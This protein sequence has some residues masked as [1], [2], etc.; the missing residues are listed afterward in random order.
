M[1]LLDVG[2]LAL[3]AIVVVLLALLAGAQEE[4][5]D[6]AM[7]WEGRVA[8]GFT[9][10]LLTGPFWLA[11][12]VVAIVATVADGG[13]WPGWLWMW[14]VAAPLLGMSPPAAWV[15]RRA[16]RALPERASG[17]YSTRGAAAAQQ[18]S[19]TAWADTEAAPG[20]ELRRT[21]AL[22]ASWPPVAGAPAVWLCYA[23]KAGTPQVFE[24]AAPFA[25]ITLAVGESAW[26]VVERLSAAVESLGVQAIVPL[27]PQQLKRKT[28][29]HLDMLWRGDPDGRL[30]NALRD[31][32]SHNGLIARHPA[33]AGHLPPD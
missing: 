17:G 3:G 6:P 33:V 13:L 29:S 28:V 19:N 10:L 14:F 24:V 27:D 30:G 11:Q 8:L 7:K 1:S 20:W 16:R 15:V 5:P 25:R 26:P 22:P 18:E 9:G 32:R 2:A 31:W 21:P 4:R 12:G 23:E